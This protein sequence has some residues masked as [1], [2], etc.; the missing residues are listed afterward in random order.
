MS[1]NLK[2]ISNCVS[3]SAYDEVANIIAKKYAD[4][5]IIV[6]G[7]P[8]R[9]Y[10]VKYEVNHEDKTIKLDYYLPFYTNFSNCNEWVLSEIA[11]GNTSGCVGLGYRRSIMAALGHDVPRVDEWG[12]GPLWAVD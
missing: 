2:N 5:S 4:Y 7:G 11:K 8:Y 12:N 1:R 9:G 6:D 3:K 10:N